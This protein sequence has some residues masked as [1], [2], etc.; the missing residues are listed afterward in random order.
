M[1]FDFAEIFWNVWESESFQRF[2]YWVLFVDNPVRVVRLYQESVETLQ[3]QMTDQYQK[4][5]L[6]GVRNDQYQTDLTL[7]ED[8]IRSLKNLHASFNAQIHGLEGEKENLLEALQDKEQLIYSLQ[9]QVRD[10][11]ADLAEARVEQEE[12]KKMDALKGVLRYYEE[13]C[14]NLER[15]ASLYADAPLQEENEGYN[16]RNMPLI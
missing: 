16:P 12:I 5:D 10:L 8:M 3:Q 1:K 14:R 11:Q 6:L 2:L 13:K 7:K 9:I 4:I 15:R